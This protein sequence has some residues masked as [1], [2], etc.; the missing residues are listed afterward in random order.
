M[1][2]SVRFDQSGDALQ[3]PPQDVAGIWASYLPAPADHAVLLRLGG[4]TDVCRIVPDALTLHGIDVQGYLVLPLHDAQQRLTG[5]AYLPH[6]PDGKLI[7]C[8]DQPNDNGYH[9]CGGMLLNT[10]RLAHGQPVYVVSDPTT[11]FMLAKALLPVVVSLTPEQWRGSTPKAA[12]NLRYQVQAW[13]AAGQAVIVP[14]E[15]KDLKKYQDWLSDAGAMV[16]GIEGMNSPS[17]YQPL[18]LADLIKDSLTDIADTKTEKIWCDPQPI[19]NELPPV[20]TL[21][22]GMLPRDLE[23]Y[24]FD[25]ADRVPMPPDM[26]AVSV[27][28]ALCSLLGARVA[29]KPKKYD[30]F[31]I[32]PNL[33]GAFVAPPSSKKSGAFSAGIK[34]LDALVFVAQERFAEELAAFELSKKQAKMLDKSEDKARNAQIDKIMRAEGREAAAAKLAE[35]E[36]ADQEAGV[37]EPVLKRYKTNDSSPE[38]LAVLEQ[39]NPTGIL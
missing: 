11:G 35:L 17:F 16:V 2:S 18:E 22:V 26:V 31:A 7:Y 8:S 20:K 13:S 36:K 5:L 34:P 30:D 28:T 38:A 23:A 4:F 14:V 25:Q 32:V 19:Q 33:W 9:P 37:P 1:N 39:G 27:L 6:D 15:T 29:I 24:I 3:Q 10:D 12:M 21:Q